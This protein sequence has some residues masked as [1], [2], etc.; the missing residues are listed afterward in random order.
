MRTLRGACLCG[1]LQIT[2]QTD[3]DTAHE[4]HCSQCRRQSGHVWAFVTVKADAVTVTG[5]A[6]TYAH[7]ETATR[8]FCPD[9]GSFL[10]WRGNDDDTIDLSA[11]LFDA[12]T[13]LHL[14]KPSFP[15]NKGDYYDFMDRGAA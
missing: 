7:T 8:G 14:G 3:A 15:G 12:P 11:G 6:Q 1:Q 5:D 9:C 4:C 13:G 10:W 2:A